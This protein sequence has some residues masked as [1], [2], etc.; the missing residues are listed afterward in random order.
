MI[1][2]LWYNDI[3]GL[4]KEM[5][6]MNIEVKMLKA[7]YHTDSDAGFLLR[8]IYGKT[9]RFVMHT[10]DFYELFLIVSGDIT[11]C[12]NGEVHILKPGSLVFMRPDDV[13][14]YIYRDEPDY[15]FINLAVRADIL[16][17][18]FK[19]LGDIADTD[20]LL[21]SKLPVVERLTM[22]EMKNFLRKIDYF[23]TVDSGESVLKKLKI[24]SFLADTFVKY[25]LGRT[26][27][28]TPSDIPAWL[29]ETVEKMRQK[30]NFAE[31]IRRMVE[32]SGKTQEH[33]AR[34][35]KKYYGVTLSGFVNEL[36][37][38]YAAN[39]ILNTNLKI[40]DVCYESGFGNI[41]NFYANFK[42][43]Y[44]VSPK[45]FRENR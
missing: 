27:Y 28:D 24:R 41:S 45:Q 16:D 2:I 38:N 29:E 6:V 39:L 7:K 36:R 19:Y 25:F 12:I 20:F 23:Y 31:G 11:H 35:V 3:A 18:M 10:H 30:D 32:I 26:T 21:R 22:S 17:G 14:T 42:E 9:E 40:I 8:H 43:A 1:Y 4:Q 13:H 33:L 5:F 34:C 15:E 44:G 37:V